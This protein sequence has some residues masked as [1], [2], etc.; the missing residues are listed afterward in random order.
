MAYFPFFVDID[1]REGL[2]AGGGTVALRKA[3]KLLPYGPRLTVIAPH[4]LPELQNIPS[5]TCLEKDFTPSALQGKDFVIAATDDASLNGLISRL[6][7]EAHIPVNVVDDKELCSF[8]FPALVKRGEL[9]VGISTAGAS[10]SAAV[11]VKE[12]VEAALP[13]N[14]ES[15]LDFL[16]TAREQVKARV[17]EPRRGQVLRDLFTLCAEKGSPFTEAEFSAFLSEVSP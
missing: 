9:S 10:P 8:L 6:C 17:S 12:Q 14:F 3:E 2:I 7:R 5:I 4:I 15:I 1:G 13:E 11:Y 16:S